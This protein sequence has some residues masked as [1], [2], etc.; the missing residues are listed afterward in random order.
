MARRYIGVVYRTDISVPR[1]VGACPTGKG[2][3][4]ARVRDVAGDVDALE[5]VR[6]WLGGA[7]SRDERQDAGPDRERQVLLVVLRRARAD[8]R[9]GLLDRDREQDRLAELV[10][11][12]HPRLVLA[13]RKDVPGDGPGRREELVRVGDLASGAV[14]DDAPVVHRVV[15]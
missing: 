12:G 7:G 14:E 4:A 9:R 6:R 8:L 10:G 1:R 15:E 2:S 13:T 3:G 5:Q 11:R